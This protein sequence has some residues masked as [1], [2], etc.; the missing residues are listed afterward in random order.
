MRVDACLVSFDA[1]H[2]ELR[3]ERG[4]FQHQFCDLVQVRPKSA[5]AKSLLA[6]GR[7]R[8]ADSS[9]RAMV[10]SVS[11]TNPALV[12]APVS[13]QKRTLQTTTNMINLNENVARRI[14]VNIPPLITVWAQLRVSFD[15]NEI[16]GE[17]GTRLGRDG[18]SPQIRGLKT[19]PASC[20]PFP[21]LS[22]PIVR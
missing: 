6:Q 15:D 13:R 17:T 1:H 4:I 10:I 14:L 9:R 20:S 21:L 19:R 12:G 11:A 7:N 5:Y 3:I 2:D 16:H 22:Y 18:L 8:T